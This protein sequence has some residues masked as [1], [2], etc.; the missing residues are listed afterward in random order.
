MNALVYL[1]HA[2]FWSAFLVRALRKAPRD[3][4]PSASGPAGSGGAPRAARHPRLVLFFHGVGFGSMYYSIGSVVR[5]PE[6]RQA[7]F[8]L[9]WW[10]GAAVILAGGA[11]FAWA[12]L[13]FDSWRVLPKLDADHRLCTRGPYRL[14][15]HPIYAAC[16]LLA[17]G[18][19]LWL[20]T[21]RML[22]ASML[23]L[24]GA[25]LRARAEEKLL[26]GVF[27]EEYRRYRETTKRFLPGIY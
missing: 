20:P 24:L 16:D 27:G 26:L 15:R 6:P 9:P 19:Y 5:S 14:L 4:A 2:I 25:E 8:P 7:A 11:L 1:F 10:I 22:V 12:L 18:T 21:V 3:P 23:M 17:I 13:V